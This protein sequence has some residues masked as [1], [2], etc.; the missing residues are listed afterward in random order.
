[1]NQRVLLRTAVILLVIALSIGMISYINGLGKDI[2][3]AHGE[4]VGMIAA[5]KLNDSGNQLVVIDSNG[6]LIEV[7]GYQRDDIDREPVWRPD[8]ERLFFASDRKDAKSQNNSSEKFIQI[9]RWRPGS[10]AVER[11]SVGGRPKGT[12][13]FGPSGVENINKS[14]LMTSSGTVIEYL[15]ENGNTFQILP[16]PS[17]SAAQ[18]GGDESGVTSAMDAIYSRLGK[19]FRKARY[20]PNRDSVVAIMRREQGETVVYQSMIPI[21]DPTGKVALPRP[22][23]IATGQQLE[24]DIMNDGKIFVS[25][26]GLSLNE[27]E[28][29]P[30]QFIKNGKVTLPYENS[31]FIFDPKNPENP[32]SFVFVSKERKSA[33]INPIVSPNGETLLVTEA[34]ID[35]NGAITPKILRLLTLPLSESTRSVVLTQGKVFEASFTPQNDRILY[36]KNEKGFRGIYMNDFSGTS[37]KLISPNG[38]NFASPAMSPQVSKK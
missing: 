34:S 31:M 3:W 29:I 22:V 14:A 5:L 16:P 27:N 13:W 11:R 25:V 19:S 23:V 18:S 28:E 37:E 24:F 7:P 20:G 36:V 30:E 8:G 10:D 38:E 35:E 15:P 4:S 12:P 26:V 9:Y 6:K 17:G 2:D 32:P 21:N 33:L 1:M